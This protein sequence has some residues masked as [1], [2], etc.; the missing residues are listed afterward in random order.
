MG[1]DDGMSLGS[2]DGCIVWV[3]F[4]DG[5]LEGA[6]DSEGLDEPNTDGSILRLGLIVGAVDGIDEGDREGSILGF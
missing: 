1:A 5:R 2:F 4:T 6:E 3:G